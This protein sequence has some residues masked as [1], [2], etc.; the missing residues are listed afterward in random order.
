MLDVRVLMQLATLEAAV[1]FLQQQSLGGGRPS[2]PAPNSDDMDDA[3]H[4]L[5]PCSHLTLGTHMGL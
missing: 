4:G 1:A 3:K 2:P 5:R